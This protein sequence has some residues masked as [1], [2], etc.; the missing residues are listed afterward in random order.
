MLI[1]EAL[2]LIK[3]DKGLK[4][5]YDLAI[6]LKVSQGTISNYYKGKSYPTLHIAAKIYG[7][8]GH[9][10]EPFTELSLEKEWAYIQEYES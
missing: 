1:S 3:E 10:V 5:Q 8:H 4:D 2:D 9:K 6:L 7:N